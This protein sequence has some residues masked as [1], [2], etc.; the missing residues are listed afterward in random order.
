MS[1]LRKTPQLRVAP[2]GNETHPED[3]ELADALIAGELWAATATYDKHSAMVFR[4]L[5]RALG[6]S[7]GAEDLTQEV[8]LQVFAKVRGLRNRHALRSFIFSVAIRTLK[9]ELRR[10]R[11]RRIFQTSSFDRIPEP[12]VDALDA[13]SR[14]AVRRLYVILDALSVQERTAF[15]L[16]HIEH[17]TLDEVAEALGLSLATVKRRLANATRIVS[18]EMDRDP[19]LAPY[20]KRSYDNDSRGEHEAS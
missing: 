12:A 16:R 3:P 10:R 13:E 17:L 5:Q 18:Q 11:V 20:S 8:F 9:W 15:V 6:A 7:G 14:Q 2:R 4:F 1:A 19:S